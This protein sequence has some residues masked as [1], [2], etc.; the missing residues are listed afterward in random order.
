M[1]E[2]GFTVSGGEVSR[3]EESGRS[4]GDVKNPPHLTPTTEVI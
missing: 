4:L 3:G 1:S 2:T